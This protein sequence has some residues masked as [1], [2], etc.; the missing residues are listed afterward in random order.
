MCRWH[1]YLRE[2]AW[3]EE[4]AQCEQRQCVVTWFGCLGPRGHSV[5]ARAC[6]G[7]KAA[8]CTAAR[9]SQREEGPESP[10]T[11]QGRAPSDLTSSH[12]APPPGGLGTYWHLETFPFRTQ[13]AGS[14]HWGQGHVSHGSRTGINHVSRPLRCRN[15]FPQQNGANPGQVV[16][17]LEGQV[18]LRASTGPLLGRV[19]AQP[20]CLPLSGFISRCPSKASHMRRWGFA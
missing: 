10:Q 19:G 12:Q 2:T 11:L 9:C 4:E 18:T 3:K 16:V 15:R 8:Q 14:Q 1:K 13:R 7:G 6:G 17:G 5:M 20:E